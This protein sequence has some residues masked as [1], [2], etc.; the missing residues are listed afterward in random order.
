MPAETLALVSHVSRS[1]SGRLAVDDVSFEIRR[2][3]ALGLLGPNGAGKTTTMRMLCGVLAPGSG[4]IVVGGHDIAEAPEAAKANIGYLPEQLPL[5]PD[6]TVD[7]YLEFCAGLR[8][9]PRVR[10]G[11]A[12]RR[13]RD[14]C[15]LL[16]VGGRL[17]GNLSKGFQQRVGVA[18]AI[19]HA[20]ALIVLDEPTAGLDPAQIVETRSLI[21][22]LSANHGVLI[23]THILSEVRATCD[24]VLIIGNGRLLLDQSLSAINDAGA[25]AGFTAALRAPP[26]LQTLRSLPQVA[27]VEQVDAQRFRVSTANSADIAAEFAAAATRGGWGLFELV[28]DA[29]TLE[30]TFLRLTR[31]DGAGAATDVS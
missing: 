2:G 7:R 19:I 4:R 25:G 11:E 29:G 3:E 6:L 23:S 27:A 21:R 30:Q 9:V 1:F 8:R 22:E 17:V 5:Y 28:P 10:L 24:R 16:G 12:V 15:G 20:P 26:D 18:Q 13:A 14:R 31:G